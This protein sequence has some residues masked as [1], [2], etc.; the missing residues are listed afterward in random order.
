MISISATFWRIIS[1]NGSHWLEIGLD[2]R[3][4]AISK[5]NESEYFP[6][7]AQFQSR[8]ILIQFTRTGTVPLRHQD[9]KNR[10]VTFA[11]E[12][13]LCRNEQQESFERW[14]DHSVQQEIHRGV[15]MEHQS[16]MATEVH[17]R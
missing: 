2:G 16:I 7:I 4:L 11:A 6:S 9:S 13:F 1:I 17:R 15:T 12:D 8:L 5:K 14:G 3:G 10:K